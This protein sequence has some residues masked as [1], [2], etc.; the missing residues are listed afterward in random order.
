MLAT[1]QATYMDVLNFAGASDQINWA[2]VFSDS[3]KYMESYKQEITFHLME[4]TDLRQ[5]KKVRFVRNVKTLNFNGEKG[6]TDF[7][8]KFLAGPSDFINSD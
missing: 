6:Q 3:N 5:S 4:P 7:E 1:N 8:P 2:S